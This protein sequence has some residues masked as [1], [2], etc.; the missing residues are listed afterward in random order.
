MPKCYF[1]F[2]SAIGYTAYLIS[3]KKKMEIEQDTHNTVQ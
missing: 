2:E 3:L 1:S